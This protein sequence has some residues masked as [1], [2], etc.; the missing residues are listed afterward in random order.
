MVKIIFTMKK[1]TTLTQAAATMQKGTDEEYVAAAI[2]CGCEELGFSDHA[3]MLFP[4]S[5]GYY[6]DFRIAPEFAADY[7]ASIKKLKKINIR[8]KSISGSALSLNIIRRFLR[9]NLNF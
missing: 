6:S 2:S 1:I 8:L 3:P 5:S 4:K 7:A 9:M